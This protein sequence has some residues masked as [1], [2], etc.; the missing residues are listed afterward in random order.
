MKKVL[1][2]IAVLGIVTAATAQPSVSFYATSSAQPYGLSDATNAALP[3][4]GEQTDSL[5]YSVSDWAHGPI[6][7]DI[8]NQGEWAYIWAK[9]TGIVPAAFKIQGLGVSVRLNGGT[10]GITGIWYAGDDLAESGT[11]RWDYDVNQPFPTNDFVTHDFVG[12]GVEGAGLSG[13]ATAAA[14]PSMRQRVGAANAGAARE[15]YFLLGAVTFDFGRSVGGELSVGPFQD[16]AAFNIDVPGLVVSGATL[17][18][19]P[20]PASFLLIALGAL[21]LRRR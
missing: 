21:A 5:Y 11:I 10:D 1:G 8:V 16:G 15:F 20:E 4:Q 14:A 13:G 3:T 17:E 19:V 2:L 9:V 6:A 7:G 18:V 12:V